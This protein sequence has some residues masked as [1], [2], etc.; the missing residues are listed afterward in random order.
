MI[1]VLKHSL[2][3]AN[4]QL[5]SD[6]ILR[7]HTIN[8]IIIDNIILQFAHRIDV[9]INE[10]ELDR[11][12]SYIANQNHMSLDQMCYFFSYDGIDYDIYREKIR[13]EILIT[14]I[15]NSEVRRRITIF[16]QEIELLMQKIST[17]TNSNTEYNLSYILIPLPNKK[18][19]QNQLD[20]AKALAIS[21]IKK[22]RKV[23][24]LNQLAI[25]YSTDD[26]VIKSNH[27]GWWKLEELSPLFAVYLKGAHKNSIIG[28]IRSNVGFYVLKVNDIRNNNKKMV[29]TEV[30][31][32]HILLRT[33]SILN[34]QQAHAKLEDIASQIRN[35]HIN[36]FTAAK[37]L[38]EDPS[39][40]NQGGDLGW[41]SIDFFDPEF[42]DILIS[43]K[44]G[45]VS[46]PIHSSFGWH[47]IQIIDTRKV[48]R[49]ETIK[50]DHAYRLLFNYKFSEEAKAWIQEQRAS[51]YIKILNNNEK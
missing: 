32:R 44:K 37:K 12:I 42:Y 19:T 34:D 31:V 43:L 29:M 28:P 26:Q 23:A 5:L 49:I 9:H 48:D 35:G 3:K 51:A 45:E 41:I 20:K 7:N 46:I 8:Q 25:T 13:K 14:K 10:K 6:K 15:H 1:S 11:S 27:M 2:K 21:L 4:Q 16:P 22:G 33:S 18:Q 47:L 40:A 36:F 39:S 24:D 50:K 38:S 30:Y 17:K